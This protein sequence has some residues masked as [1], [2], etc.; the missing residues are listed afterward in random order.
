MNLIDKKDVN[1]WKARSKD[2]E[3]NKGIKLFVTF[4]NVI[5]NE[6]KN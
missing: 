6:Q 3:M 1:E 4:Y 2:F 5:E